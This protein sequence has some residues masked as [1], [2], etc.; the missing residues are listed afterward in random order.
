[1]NKLYGGMDLHSN[2]V[3]IVIINMLGQRVFKKRFPNDLELILDAL[4]KFR[5]EIFAVVVESTYNW[6]WLVDG[7]KDA[8]YDVRLANVSKIKGDTGQK[9]TNDF[10]DAYHLADLLRIDRLPEGYIY[11]KKDRPIRDLMRKRSMLVRSRTKFFLNMNSFSSRQLGY[12]MRVGD[13]R[14]LETTD[15]EDLFKE[16]H[17]VLSGQCN[18]V[19]IN[20]F[21]H[22]INVLEKEILSSIKLK[23]EFQ[24]LLTI[25]GVGDVLGLTIALET[26]YIKRFPDAGNYASYCRAVESKKISNN[27]KKGEN[28]RK[29]GNVYLG[30]AFIEAANY[31]KRFCPEAMQFYNHKLRQ[32]NKKVIALKSLACKLAK[33]SYFI[34]RDQ[35]DFDLDKIFPK[36]KSQKIRCGSKPAGEVGKTTHMN[37]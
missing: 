35:V 2:N 20:H 4:E 30:W 14:K 15:L 34:M 37:G 27:K 23:P 21:D 7:L 3:C 26:G 18:T 1:M 13:I 12:S 29:N 6:Y 36:T 9:H 31:C 10:T 5:E 8:G 17:L 11:P 19:F 33:A 16:K 22:W 28:N 25:I 32:T 24:K